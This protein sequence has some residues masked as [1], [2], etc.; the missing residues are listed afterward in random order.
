MPYRLDP[1]T[2]QFVWDG[3]SIPQTTRDSL[4][5]QIRE[6][7]AQIDA[8]SF[9]DL[10]DVPT[11]YTGQGGKILS[12]KD[13]ED[14]VE[15]IENTGGGG[16]SDGDKG[17]V[18]VSSSGTVWTL[19]TT[20]VTAGSYTN[21]NLTVDSKGRITAASNGTSGTVTTV[22]VVTANGV[23]GSVANPTST[24]AITLT[25]GAITPSSVNGVTITNGGSGALTVTG[26]AG[27]SGSNSGDVTINAISAGYLTRSGQDLTAAAINLASHVTG[28][29]PVSN[30]G[31]GGTTQA[32]ARSGIGIT[33]G[34]VDNA[35]LRAHETGGATLQDSSITIGDPTT[36][37]N[38]VAIAVAHA[39][40]TNS[41]LTLTP[42]GTGALIVGPAPD[43]TATGGNARGDDAIDLQK[44][45]AANTQVASGM[46][47]A[48]IGGRNHT[49][50]GSRSSCV[51]G[52]ANSATAT[53]S[54]AL[55]GTGNTASGLRSVVIGGYSTTASGVDTVSIGGA[56]S[57][58]SAQNGVVFGLNALANRQSMHAHAYGQFSGNG[59]AQ[60]GV[61]VVRRQTTDATQTE[62]TIDGAT[63]TGTAATTSNRFIL[64]NNQT[65]MA[66][67]YVV[68][69]SATGTNDAGYHR[70][71]LI[72]RDANAAS[73]AITG[74]QTIGT[75]METAGASAWD[76]TLAAD[77]TNG[78]LQVLVTGAAGTNI[79]WFAE[80]QFREVI[81]A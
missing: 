69:R 8:L 46:Q 56:A 64:L 62:L 5:T 68:A 2:G 76:V 20:A 14:G 27:I 60:R 74:L 67:V 1:N 45:R 75:D 11:T 6:L 51:G 23:S 32:T 61:V 81:R 26:T 33:T 7:Q 34:S 18:V 43:G 72:T 54:S 78:S 35:V 58:A 53:Q 28:T 42:Q 59:D 80:I 31:T 44:I 70:R 15:F 41:S 30:G 73:T 63:P 52:D 17:D 13:T 24:P 29:L 3:S 48:I 65:V 71:V 38:S 55:A 66:D 50:S 40:Q 39:G 22:S 19:D 57:T 36:F 21:A 12:V 9:I 16:V 49:A 47:T 79:N 10:D 77:T 37:A 4:G 25:L